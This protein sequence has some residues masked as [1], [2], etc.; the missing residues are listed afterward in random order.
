VSYVLFHQILLPQFPVTAAVNI[1]SLL[2]FILNFE[3]FV[4]ARCQRLV[5]HQGTSWF[6]SFRDVFFFCFVLAAC[7]KKPR[8]TAHVMTALMS[9]SCVGYGD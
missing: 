4:V 6:I 7:V 1:C 3:A 5:I 2:N 8:S 9:V